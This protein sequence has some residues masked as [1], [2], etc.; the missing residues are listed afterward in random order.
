[1]YILGPMLST[2]KYTAFYLILPIALQDRIDP[3]GRRGKGFLEK[4]VPEMNTDD[5]R[6]RKRRKNVTL[7]AQ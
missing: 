1:M 4:V 6:K 5:W 2:S 7:Q 3:V